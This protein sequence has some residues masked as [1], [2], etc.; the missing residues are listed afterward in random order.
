MLIS[1]VFA[2]PIAADL[3]LHWP[4]QFGKYVRY[5]GS[6]KAGHHTVGQAIRYI[7]W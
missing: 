5:S 7:L 1:A 4:G 2:L 6:A 3:I